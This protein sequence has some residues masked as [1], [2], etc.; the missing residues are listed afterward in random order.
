M[1]SFFQHT[2]WYELTIETGQLFESA[3]TANVY[4]KIICTI[5]SSPIFW[6]KD[7]T[8]V[9]R[10]LFHA[11]SVVNF[12]VALSKNI[13]SPTGL[14]IWHDITGTHPC[15]FL[16]SVRIRCIKS[17]TVLVFPIHSW[18]SFI[19]G[20]N[21]PY[22]RILSEGS[23][24][25]PQVQRDRTNMEKR[26]GFALFEKFLAN[27]HLWLGV[28]CSSP[29]SRFN[30]RERLAC[31]L[32]HV[33]II[34]LVTSILNFDDSK[35][36][37]ISCL[38]NICIKDLHVVDG[39]ISAVIAFLPTL[40][41][42]IL[43]E[44]TPKFSQS[45]VRKSGLTSSIKNGRRDSRRIIGRRRVEAKPA[46]QSLILASSGNAD[47]DIQSANEEGRPPSD[48]TK[49]QNKFLQQRNGETRFNSSLRKSVKIRRR[50]LSAIPENNISKPK[51]RYVVNPNVPKSILRLNSNDACLPKE[52]LYLEWT[53][54][55]LAC[56]VCAY[57]SWLQSR[58]FT[59]TDI[60]NWI[61]AIL[62]AVLFDVIVLQFIRSLV[63]YFWLVLRHR[64]KK[65]FSLRDIVQSC[66]NIWYDIERQ[67]CNVH[68][69][70]NRMAYLDSIN[71]K[72]IS[73]PANLTQI[74]KD[75]KRNIA[76]RHAL[77]EFPLLF[78]LIVAFV[79]TVNK[80]RSSLDFFAKDFISNLLKTSGDEFSSSFKSVSND[81]CLSFVR[82]FC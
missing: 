6:L 69:H 78:L 49:T 79:F 44:L 39:I 30:K 33:L 7:T 73:L 4:I 17:N 8:H 15:W 65:C 56:T 10:N 66:H 48:V 19:K 5:D 46:V 62:S 43:F 25:V 20:D 37:I 61:V 53:I 74:R 2:E 34:V 29:L 23:N 22:L 28:F 52:M 31:L 57:K 82:I 64:E 41:M 50:K 11:G 42:S 9:E 35:A 16:S 21:K 68:S 45:A 26:N 47:H 54:I 71:N 67:W 80:E 70:V 58:T 77:R 24:E 81:D 59:L 76:R 60:T 14:H 55:I 72:G 3:T 75:L 27:H 32:F 51:H 18:L 13:G 12:L 63:Q 38:N 36:A 1:Q 40:F